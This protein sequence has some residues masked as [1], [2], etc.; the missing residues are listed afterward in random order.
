MDTDETKAGTSA[1]GKYHDEVDFTSG[2]ETQ[3]RKEYSPL[4]PIYVPPP[5]KKHAWFRNWSTILMISFLSMVF[6]LGTVTLVVEVFSASPLQ[7]FMIVAI[8]VSISAAVI[9]LE[10]VSIKVR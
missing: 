9:W 7:I 6:I 5:D 3:Y 2:Y 4:K 10:V 8:Y 1:P